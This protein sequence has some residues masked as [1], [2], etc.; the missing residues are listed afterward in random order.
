[1]VMG[2][3]K[4]ADLNFMT[5]ASPP[6]TLSCRVYYELR[7]GASCPGAAHQGGN[8]PSLHSLHCNPWRRR[9][10]CL[11]GMVQNCEHHETSSIYLSHSNALPTST[12]IVANLI[13]SLGFLDFGIC[14]IAIED[15]LKS[16]TQIPRPLA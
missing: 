14:F 11:L 12:F 1:M 13:D 2:R 9:G 4:C 10:K 7:C 5:L 8:A 15:L 16:S 3:S 6:V